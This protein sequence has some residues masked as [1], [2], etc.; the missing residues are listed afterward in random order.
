MK[1]ALVSVLLII[2]IL[3]PGCGRVTA[4]DLEYSRPDWTHHQQVLDESCTL[5][6]ESDNLKKVVNGIFD[7]Y[8]VYDEFNT[9]YCLAMINHFRDMTDLYWEQEYDF[10]AEHISE[11]DAG[12][13]RLFRTLAQSPL[14]DKL[15]TDEYFGEGFFDYY[16]GESVFDEYLN[17]LLTEEAKLESLH[18]DYWVAGDV[19]AMAQVYV[20]LILL[21]NEMADYC[22]YDSYPE[23]AYDFY[24]G[25]D[26]TV[27]QATSY[28]ADVRAEL[29]PLYRKL[30]S[31]D[32]E[33][34]NTLVS[35]SDVFSYVSGMS[36]R[37]GG[38]V[39]Q[40]FR[41]LRDSQ[42]YDI[43]YSDKKYDTSFEV[44]LPS[45]Q[46][47]YL[48][49]NPTGAAYDKLTLAHEFGHF[50]SDYAVQG[51]T[52]MGVDVSEIFSQGMEYLSLF[53]A[54]GGEELERAKLALTLADFVEQAAYASFEHQVYN[55]PEE[56][57]TAENIANLFAS[58]CRGYG[59]D[60]R[61]MDPYF[62]VE[63]PHFFEEPMYVISYVL[64]NDA[65]F[66]IYEL[67]KAEKGA[68]LK[69]YTKNI[70]TQQPQLLGFLEEAGLQ[71]PFELQRMQRIK[72]TLQSVIG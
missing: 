4:S 42:M 8:A 64:S 62:F 70:T 18:Q 29:T 12:I 32:F 60:A 9:Q 59:L 25:R 21:R 11:L 24:F 23:F 50:C 52:M 1:K 67:E 15:E 41:H 33:A 45:Y 20:D 19:P 65:A 10:C 53:Y 34:V 58:V 43:T 46:T 27:E 72:E 61:K 37:M 47:P 3:L 66:Q 55:L 26:Y 69:C 14:R 28:L 56:S 68:G 38:L 40:S 71:S 5:A 30:T 13:D 6:L 7:Y 63:I 49:M 36:N 54:D 39:Y 51:G 44:Y 48:F 31:K 17:S 35:Q 16:E 57:L 2:C 22:G